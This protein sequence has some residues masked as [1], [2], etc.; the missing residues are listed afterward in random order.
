MLTSEQLDSV[1][2]YLSANG[3]VKRDDIARDLQLHPVK[4]RQA[5]KECLTQRDIYIVSDYNEG[6]AIA[7]ESKDF[8]ESI[9]RLKRMGVTLLQEVRELQRGQSKFRIAEGIETPENQLALK[10]ET[11]LSLKLEERFGQ[12]DLFNAPK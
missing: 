10:E 9:R 8:D 11:E 2:N 6:F 5:R 12:Q 1:I 4:I 7:K 3:R